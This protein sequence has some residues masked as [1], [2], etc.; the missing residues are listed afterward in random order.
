[1]TIR[2]A[3]TAAS[4]LLTLLVAAA[5]P[6]WEQD[7]GHQ[8][9]VQPA[10]VDAVRDP[11]IA[12]HEGDP[13]FSRR[14]PVR[15]NGRLVWTY[16]LVITEQ[17]V[18]LA[19][20]AMY[21][22]WAYGNRIPGPTLRAGEGDLVRVQVS[23]ETSASHT[24]H[25][26]GLFVPEKM[27]GVPPMSPAIKPGESFTY[28]FIATPSGTHFYHCHV[29]SNEH[30]NRGM[31]G[32]F[33][34]T[35]KL[36]EPAVDQ[37]LVLMLGEWNSKYAQE[38]RPGSPQDVFTADIFTFN[39]RSFPYTP[40]IKVKVGD[41]VRLRLINVGAQ[42]H[43]IHLHGHSFLVTHKDGKALAEPMEMDT[44]PVS[45]GER[46]DILFRASTEGEWPIHCHT[47]AHQTN[48]GSYPGGMMLHLLVTARENGTAGKRP[49]STRELRLV[50]KASAERH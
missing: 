6:G 43:S 1:M 10:I 46:I 2:S 9:A 5:V 8:H 40:Q 25:F 33:I 24:I 26:H 22:V 28:E 35:P 44:V 12:D 18:R 21:K 39:A 42:A 48:A 47:P 38:G 17:E 19:N 41:I 7:S 50:W 14:G 3:C 27:D 11:N 32:A 15:E 45:P 29:D 30:L 36:P 20:G 37:D 23:N 4:W 34:V 16:K 13:Y 31:S 49:G